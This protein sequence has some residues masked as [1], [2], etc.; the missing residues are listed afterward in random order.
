MALSD[1]QVRALMEMGDIGEVEQRQRRQE[2]LANQLRQNVFN[3]QRM[4][5][6]SQASRALS[7]LFSGM[8][9]RKADKT[10]KEVSGMYRDALMRLFPMRGPEIEPNMPARRLP[11]PAAPTP[12]MPTPQAM[13]MPTPQPQQGMPMPAPQMPQSPQV[14]ALTGG[15]PSAI[16]GTPL[17]GSAPAGPS[18]P[19]QGVTPTDERAANASLGGPAYDPEADYMRQMLEDE[20]LERQRAANELRLRKIREERAQILGK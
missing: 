20:D 3:Q 10:G 1:E 7:G 6:G 11:T 14:Q 2:L 18:L 9:Q 4:D 15:A 8:A 13:P 17:Q 19:F 5:T 12:P 16:Q